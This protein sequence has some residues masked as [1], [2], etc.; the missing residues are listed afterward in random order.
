MKGFD[1]ERVRRAPDTPSSLQC[2]QQLHVLA[3]HAAPLIRFRNEVIQI[4]KKYLCVYVYTWC[5]HRGCCP[6]PSLPPPAR[7]SLLANI[8]KASN[9]CI[10]MCQ[11]CN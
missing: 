11:P 9:C 2:T 1:L 7:H 4:Y 3:A 5:E 8:G 10:M 6:D